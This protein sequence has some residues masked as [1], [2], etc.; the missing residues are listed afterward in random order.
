[1]MNRMQAVD[2]GST[3]TFRLNDSKN[4]HNEI[5]TMTSQRGSKVVL[6]LLLI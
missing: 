5:N 4:V 6:G 3:G 1:M 2:V